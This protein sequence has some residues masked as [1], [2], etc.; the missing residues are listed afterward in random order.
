MKGGLAN[1]V[2]P[3]LMTG[4]R[5]PAL[6]WRLRNGFATY[7][8]PPNAEVGYR[9]HVIT[10]YWHAQDWRWVLVD[11]QLDKLQRNAIHLNFLTTFSICCTVYLYIPTM[12]I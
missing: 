11:A 7:I 10:E 12:E 9:E 1:T 6:E 2:Y 4:H 5:N 8:N 3:Y